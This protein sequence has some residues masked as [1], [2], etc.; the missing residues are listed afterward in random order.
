MLSGKLL[1][2]P[3]TKLLNKLPSLWNEDDVMPI[4]KLLSGRTAIDG[5]GDNSEGAWAFAMISHEFNLFLDKH[6]EIRGLIDP[7][8]VVADVGG[9]N[10][11]NFQLNRYP[12][13]GSP[14]NALTQ[15]SDSK[16]IWAFNGA[17]GINRA[18]HLVGWIQ[19]SVP[20]IRLFVFSTKSPA[21]YF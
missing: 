2:E 11:P 4:A 13:R 9:Q 18:Q 7:T 19:A 14:I 21:Q 10:L 8:Y 16:Y 15:Y 17:G 20:G 1:L 3:A 5:T 12:P 6:D